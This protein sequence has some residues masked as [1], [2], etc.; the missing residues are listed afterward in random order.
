M[1]EAHMSVAPSYQQVLDIN[2]GMPEANYKLGIIYNKKKKFDLSIKYLK[3]ARDY[4]DSEEK[5]IES[6]YL[7][8]DYELFD[9]ELRNIKSKKDSSVLLQQLSSHAS[10]HLKREDEYNFCREV[11]E[12]NYIMLGNKKKD[13]I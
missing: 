12:D 13:I 1:D 3:V 8:Q 10:I 5:I 6:R 2:P 9:N 11:C 7:M 4:L